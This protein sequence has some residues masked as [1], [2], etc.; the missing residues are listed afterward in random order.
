M[1][2]IENCWDSYQQRRNKIKFKINE[3]KSLFY[4]RLLNSKNSKQ[5]RKT[6]HRIP[7]SCENT[8][9]CKLTKLANFLIIS[10]CVAG[11]SPT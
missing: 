10:Q 4:E 5:I 6:I 11:K 1:Y 9:K 7:N 8:V 2:K 3:T